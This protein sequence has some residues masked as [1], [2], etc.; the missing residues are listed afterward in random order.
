MATDE[1]LTEML[2]L[3]ISGDDRALGDLLQNYRPLLTAMSRDQMPPSLQPRI[4]ESDVVQASFLSAVR[5]IEGFCG[6]EP[7]EFVAWLKRIHRQ[8]LNDVYRDHVGTEKRS[9]F[10]ETNLAAGVEARNQD[11]TP[12]RWAVRHEDQTEVLRALKHLP[13]LQAV[14]IRL[15]HIEG[16]RLKDIAAEIDRTPQAVAG[17]L[18]RGLRTLR[19]HFDGR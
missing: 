11:D 5:N 8:N 18:K 10:N 1:E 14:A 19:K 2:R 12:S 15:R 7:A 4:G 13:V 6:D 17:L 9:I 3:A 16:K